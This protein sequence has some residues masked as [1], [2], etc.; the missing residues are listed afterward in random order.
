LQAVSN[1]CSLLRKPCAHPRMLRDDR[2]RI[3]GSQDVAV[4]VE[5]VREDI[6][7]VL[8]SVLIVTNEKLGSSVRP[9]D[10]GK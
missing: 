7:Y 5:T 1:I 3:I 4:I 2:V 6:A 10:T 9:D 8:V